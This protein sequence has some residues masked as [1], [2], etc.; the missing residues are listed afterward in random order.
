MH[1]TTCIIVVFE[2]WS[3]LIVN[4]N[5][6]KMLRQKHANAFLVV[7]PNYDSLS[8]FSRHQTGHNFCKTRILLA[9][10]FK[11]NAQLGKTTVS[12]CSKMSL[13]IDATQDLLLLI[14]QKLR[15]VQYRYGS[16]SKIMGHGPPRGLLL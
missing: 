1:H 5:V 8:C 15:I 16:L 7:L 10:L 3:F 12:Y 6:C 2:L 4:E 14:Q 9:A 11:Y 13:D